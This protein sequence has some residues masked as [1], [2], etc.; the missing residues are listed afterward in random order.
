MR[1]ESESRLSGRMPNAR[2]GR[3]AGAEQDPAFV[4][5]AAELMRDRY[6]IW[7]RLS[8]R[9]VEAASLV[10]L[11]RD[12]HGIGVAAAVAC[13]LYDVGLAM[14]LRRTGRSALWWR[15]GLDSI[16]VAAWSHAIGGPSA[17]ASLAATPLALEAGL[18]FGW[19]GLVVPAAVG[20]LAS[21]GSRATGQPI[22]LAPFLWPLIGVGLAILVDR[23]IG[24]RLDRRLRIADQEIEAAASR[25]EL[26]G[27]NSVAAGAD[28]TVDLLTRTMPL[29]SAGGR[30]LLPSRLAAWK[31]ALA[32]ASAGHASYL[33]VVVARW[34]RLRNSM[35]PDLRSD[36]E[37]RC[38]EGSGTLLLSPAQ[39]ESLDSILDGLSLSG[40]Q[41]VSAPRPAPAGRQQVLLVGD[42]RVVLAADPG[43]S[44]P[45][46]DPG[47]LVLLLGAGAILSQTPPGSDEVPLQVTVPLAAATALLA[48]WAY[49][50]VDRRGPAAHGVVLLAALALGAVD[51]L[52]ATLTMRNP[53]TDHLARFPFLLFLAWLGPLYV[54]YWRDLSRPLRRLAVGGTTAVVAAGFALLPSAVPA[55]HLFVAAVW[56]ASMLLASLRLRDILAQDEIAVAAELEHRQGTTVDAAYRRGQRLVIDLV[57]AAA[58]DAWAAYREVRAELPRA[59][60]EEFERRLAEVDRRLVALRGDET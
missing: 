43:P 3:P 59:V 4:L 15:L 31:L 52:V 27:Q 48:L 42:T 22:G 18:R 16:D 44:A 41:A 35:S 32:E 23:Y 13:A 36:V 33:G 9:F 54:V 37:L 47:P 60:A 2:S 14:W 55:G 7:W 24:L 12:G 56:P 1:T 20:G 6:F 5:E 26:A 53:Y 50:Q 17:V 28:S 38:L 19:R 8:V 57:K 10:A 46:L 30:T 45:S 40:V 39:A 58:A 29:L 49:R 21:A 51:A 34:Q 11:G 25:A